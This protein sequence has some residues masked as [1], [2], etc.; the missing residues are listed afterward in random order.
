MDT[1]LATDPR[2][3]RLVEQL[4]L[5]HRLAPGQG[6]WLDLDE[7]TYHELDITS[8]SRLHVLRRSPAEYH[9]RYIACTLADD[10][11]KAFRVGRLFH[12]A[13]LEPER[14]A[15]FAVPPKVDRRTKEGKATYAAWREDNPDAV[16][17]DADE[18][19]LALRMAE[20][21]AL[22]PLASQLCSG[23]TGVSERAMLWRDAETGQLIRARID[24][25]LELPIA[26]D[27]KSFTGTPT[28][29]SFMREV[30]RHWLHGQAA[31][32]LDGLLAVTGV[33]H[34]FPFVVVNKEEPHEVMVAEL[35]VAEIEM[36]RREYR[37]ALREL[38]WRTEANDWVAPWSAT[39]QVITFPGWAFRS[40]DDWSNEDG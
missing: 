27:A 30:L 21:I 13:V 2:D 38:A 32:Y 24:R 19:A 17:V 26:A 29:E 3:A 35:G 23:C 28:P 4:A 36:G 6:L 31:M 20:A 10:D 22:H 15:T 12:A 37:A 33:E 9:A 34:R 39:P 16:V 7:A 18:H 8:R 25:S 11:T 5:A 1:A 14:W 40:S